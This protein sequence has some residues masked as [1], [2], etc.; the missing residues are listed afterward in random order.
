M[1]QTK[2]DGRA[3]TEGGVGPSTQNIVHSGYSSNNIFSGEF[4]Y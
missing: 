3:D 4:K 2:I 1:I